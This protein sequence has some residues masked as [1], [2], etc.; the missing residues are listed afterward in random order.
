MIYNA[1]VS[2][3]DTKITIE[4]KGLHFGGKFLDYADVLSLKP[5]SHRVLIDTE[6]DGCMEI[7]ML[8]FSYD[9]F[10]QELTDCFAKRSLEALFIDD[11]PTMSVEGEYQTPDEQGRAI[12]NLYPDSVCILPQTSNAVRIPLA[13]TTQIQH[14]GYL[15]R[16]ATQTGENYTVGKMGYSTQPFAE[17]AISAADKVKKERAALIAAKK[18]TAPFTHAG[19]FRTTEPDQYWNAGFGSGCCAVELFTGDNSAT[20]LYKYSE[21]NEQFFAQLEQAMEATG[22]YREIIW[23]TDEQIK[24]NPLY[25]MAVHR[26]KAVSFLRERYAGRIIHSES[27]SQKLAEFLG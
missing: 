7:S 26:C 2:G 5:M 13:F 15:L 1:S 10:W 12:I 11:S 22:P 14:E 21:S 18:I 19:L 9:G 25:R 16:L 8:G 17:R 24:S 23:Q 27:H 3:S 6:T 20:Y 4:Q